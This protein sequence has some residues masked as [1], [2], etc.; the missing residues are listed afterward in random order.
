MGNFK[1]SKK[2]V[3]DLTSIW[4]YTFNEWSALQADKYYWMLVDACQE[5]ADNPKNGSKIQN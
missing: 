5:I 3:D 1:F 4:N 2:A